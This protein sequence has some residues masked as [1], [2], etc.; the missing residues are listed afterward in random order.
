[1][2]GP[3]P[4]VRGEHRPAGV[5]LQVPWIMAV[6]VA[7]AGC[8]SSPPPPAAETPPVVEA[9]PAEADP[10]VVARNLGP[11]YFILFNRGFSADPAVIETPSRF[12]LRLPESDAE[13][14]PKIEFLE[15][16][17][18]RKEAESSNEGKRAQDMAALPYSNPLQLTMVRQKAARLSL[19]ASYLRELA[20]R[21]QDAWNAT[22]KLGA[23]TAAYGISD[24]AWTKAVE[25][26][27]KLVSP[28]GLARDTV[29]AIT[30]RQAIQDADRKNY[31]R[32]HVLLTDM[33]QVMGEDSPLRS[34]DGRDVFIRF[35]REV[36][37]TARFED[38]AGRLTAYSEAREKE[39]LLAGEH[40]AVLHAAGLTA[41]SGFMREQLLSQ[42]ELI[43]M[44][45]I[46]EAITRGVSFGFQAPER[47]TALKG[48]LE[49]L[50]AVLRE[51][52]TGTA[53]PFRQ[54]A[55]AKEADP[56]Y[57]QRLAEFE[58]LWEASG[59]AAGDDAGAEQQLEQLASAPRPVVDWLREKA[60]VTR[61]APLLTLRQPM[62]YR[63]L[64]MI[65]PVGYDA[66]AK[67]LT[68]K[69]TASLPADEAGLADGIGAW[70]RGEPL[71]DALADGS[72]HALLA[73]YWLESGRP[74]LAR[75]ALI[76]GGRELLQRAK[77][78]P[79]EEAVKLQ[80]AAVGI[81]LDELNGYRF[82]I[83]AAEIN[84]APAGAV[85][86]SGARYLP[87][88]AVLLA[89]WQRMWE[90]C[91][92]PPLAAELVVSAVEDQVA[93]REAAVRVTD[94]RER[95]SF[96]D[97]SFT[98]GPVPDVILERAIER[99]MFGPAGDAA[100]AA[101]GL[102][103]FFLDFRW[104]SEFSPG[105]RERWRMSPTKKS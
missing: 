105:S 98:H 68:I 73:W 13:F 97:C 12:Q 9:A 40:A 66:G 46:N 93:E 44:P 33:A 87:E 41:A 48:R 52:V 95:Y 47:V 77:R 11:F 84:A 53:E 35:F 65:S 39:V 14:K 6:A 61:H 85:R 32:A 72:A 21:L 27:S 89:N 18:T 92:L 29:L 71:P 79:R 19:E 55:V 3:S 69:A 63:F 30:L 60:L 4:T 23:I 28:A 31:H 37:D 17:A 7:V 94:S 74:E 8:E 26:W 70:C 103:E 50:A 57:R 83:A 58:K 82:L 10:R 54:E 43:T 34:R 42:F 59:D 91:A 36:P 64:A 80:D 67:E 16:E 15:Q 22:P 5:A 102:Q 25:D 38:F 1:M 99:N 88:L 45:M 62:T 101:A 96:R 24:P 100:P 20:R 78:I 76:G 2:Q 51:G 49:A 81:L 90:D 104:P 56:A 75:A 86:G